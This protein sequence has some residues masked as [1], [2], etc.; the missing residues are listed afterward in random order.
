[1]F[2]LFQKKKIGSKS[3][4]ER[5]KGGFGVQSGTQ[6]SDV[7]WLLNTSESSEDKLVFESFDANLCPLP[8][9]SS[10]GNEKWKN[11]NIAKAK[12]IFK[13]FNGKVYLDD[14]LIRGV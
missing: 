8:N 13:D 1:M 2:K 7:D 14:I 10:W 9:L 4:I 11:K 6:I 3:Y 12:E 5:F